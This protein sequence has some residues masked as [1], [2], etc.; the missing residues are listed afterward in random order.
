MY[1]PT[2]Y[3][4]GLTVDTESILIL[5]LFSEIL[6]FRLPFILIVFT[7]LIAYAGA[8]NGSFSGEINI[9][10]RILI[11]YATHHNSDG[12]GR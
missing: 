5:L 3:E 8:R 4:V 2:N 12:I 9:M 1:K 6:Y 7:P 10:R 11:S